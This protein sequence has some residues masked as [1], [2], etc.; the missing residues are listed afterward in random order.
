[1]LGIRE[2]LV[3]EL[4]SVLSAFGAATAELQRE[5]VRSLAYLLPGDADVVA[6]VANE[7]RGQV[8]ADLSADG[9]PASGRVVRFEA[10]VRFHRQVWELTVPFAGD[11]VDAAGIEG[12][13]TRFEDEY[14]RRYGSGSRM[15]GAPVELVTLRAIGTASGEVSD[16]AMTNRRGVRSGTVASPAGRGRVRTARGRRGW[17]D[18]SRYDGLALRPGHRLSGPALIDERDTTVWVPPG[19]AGFG[20]PAR[21]HH[22]RRRCPGGGAPEA[23]HQRHMQPTM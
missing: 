12:L 15:L 20:D 10:D 4:S 6:K 5:R 17:Q 2:V 7:L 11:E 16:I 1:M 23:R 8:E 14:V 13:V 21:D 3:P 22:D 19:A 9:V 18:V